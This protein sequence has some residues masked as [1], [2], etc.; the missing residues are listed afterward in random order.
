MAISSLYYSTNPIHARRLGAISGLGA[1][2]RHGPLA[3]ILGF[4]AGHL[5]HSLHQ[6][7]AWSM[8]ALV[9]LHLAGVLV[10]SR[11]Q[12]ENLPLAM[13]T[14]F[15]PLREGEAAADSRSRAGLA[16]LMA[17]AML[18][19]GAWWLQGYFTQTAERPYLPFAGRAL[20]QDPLWQEECGACHLAYHPSLLPGRSWQ[21]LLENQAAHFGEDLVLDADTVRRLKGYALRHAA[22]RTATEAAWKILHRLPAE[23]TPQRITETPYWK[24]KHGAIAD[25]V[26][27]QPQ[28]NGRYNCDACH[29]DAEQ[30]WFEDGAMRIP[31]GKTA[32]AI[33]LAPYRLISSA[34]PGI[35]QQG[36][37]PGVTR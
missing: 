30:G 17:V 18:L 5:F 1:E 9:L 23:S 12:R 26:W 13:I 22:E 25:A 16:L 36:S 29:L 10:E 19:F 31:G 35:H 3:G 7:L 33:S 8:L 15:K 20:A 4:G 11:L 27:R 28:V 6:G 2:E 34:A 14:G 24:D 37:I 32:G 21:R